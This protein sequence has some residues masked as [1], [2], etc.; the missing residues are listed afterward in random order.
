MRLQEKALT[1][2][3]PRVYKRLSI[4]QHSRELTSTMASKSQKIRKGKVSRTSRRQDAIETFALQVHAVQAAPGSSTLTTVPFTA[5][6]TKRLLIEFITVRAFI[7]TGQLLMG[8]VLTTSPSKAFIAHQLNLS[9]VAFSNFF[10]LFVASQLVIVY[11]DPGDTI[12]FQFL[13]SSPSDQA[14]ADVTFCG[15]FLIP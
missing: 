14:T 5:S 9:Q 3:Q 8:L 15:R 7:P 10:T 11:V 12:S 4:I 2:N 6:Q 13:R 1:G